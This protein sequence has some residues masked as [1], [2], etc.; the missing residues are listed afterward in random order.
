MRLRR[1][2]SLFPTAMHFIREKCRMN[3]PPPGDAHEESVVM[4][5]RLINPA[6][7]RRGGGAIHISPSRRVE[8]T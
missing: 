5:V 1:S 3:L 4:L 8:I 2:Q 7:A 6:D